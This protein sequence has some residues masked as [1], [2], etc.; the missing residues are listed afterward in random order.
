MA[1][2]QEL[3]QELISEQEAAIELSDRSIGAIETLLSLSTLVISILGLIIAV[4]AI[5]GYA[6]LVREA[7]RSAKKVANRQL[8]DYLTSEDVRLLIEGCVEKTVKERMKNAF[9]VNHITQE[10][11][12][13]PVD[14][15]PSAE[16]ALKE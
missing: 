10:K 11:D 4:L 9:I 15:F 5:F 6:F 13:N 8:D 3:K 1:S 2:V 7:K 12:T 14:P 16:G